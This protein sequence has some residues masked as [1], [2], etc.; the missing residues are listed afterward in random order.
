MYV[1]NCDCANKFLANP[2]DNTIYTSHI[3]INLYN[4]IVNDII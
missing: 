1:C 2:I 3:K 4:Y